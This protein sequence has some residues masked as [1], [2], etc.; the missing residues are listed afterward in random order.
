MTPAFGGRYSI[1][2]SYGCV[3]GRNHKACVQ[4]SPIDKGD[5]SWSQGLVGAGLSVCV[6][7]LAKVYTVT[8]TYK[9]GGEI[10]LTRCVLIA[11]FALLWG[12]ETIAPKQQPAREVKSVAEADAGPVTLAPQCPLPPKCPEPVPCAVKTAK[13]VCPK[14]PEQPLLEPPLPRAGSNELIIVGAVE[15]VTVVSAERKLEARIDTGAETTSVSAQNVVQFERDGKDWVRFTLPAENND[16]E[17]QLELPLVR[18]VRIKQHEGM[19]E[20]RYVVMLRLRMGDINERVEVTL[21]DRSHMRYQ[22]LIGRNF[23]TDNAIVDV[24]Q[25]FMLKGRVPVR[26]I[27]SGGGDKKG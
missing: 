7:R 2:L 21:A 9:R 15:M 22:L 14:L 27:G 5:L 12:C 23:L 6:S 8:T 16:V 19:T 13:V 4:F 18:K 10:L 1:Q 25:K 24:S 17:T 11:L 20:R 26:E 3:E